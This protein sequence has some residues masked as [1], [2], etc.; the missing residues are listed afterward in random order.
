[1][2]RSGYSQWTSK[3][4]ARLLTL[5]ESE[6]RHYQ[7]ILAA[8]PIPLAVLAADRSII[9][10]NRAFRKMFSVGRD[11][12]AGKTLD[13]L[14]PSPVALERLV[15]RL[16]DLHTRSA[17]E[18]SDLVVGLE[19]KK[20]RLLL[21]P[22]RDDE[23]EAG[24]QTLLAVLDVSGPAVSPA[25]AEAA[26]SPPAPQPLTGE[27][28]P[29]VIWQADVSLKFTSVTGAPDRLLG[30][31]A[32]HWTRKADFFSAR[33]H[34]EDREGVIALY[35]STM[36][37]GGDCS[38]EFRV[39]TR[40]GESVWCR[41]TIHAA[42][43]AITG[44]LT[45]IDQRRQ[46]EHL[47]LIAERHAALQAL[48]ARLAHDLNNP[49]MIITGYAEE[50]LGAIPADDPHRA[51][52]EQ[53][54]AATDRIAGITGQ[55]LQFTRKHALPAQR[56]EISE[57]LRTLERQIRMAAGSGTR[58]DLSTVTPTFALAEPTQLQE[59]LLSVI[60]RVSV[61]MRGSALVPPSRE[62]AASRNRLRITCG[63]TRITE[64]LS[65]PER[66]APVLDP[67]TYAHITLQGAGP[68]LGAET[69]AFETLLA[70]GKEG[71]GAT[72]PARAYQIVREWGGD[73]LYASEPTSRDEKTPGWSLV[74]YLPQAEPGEA[75]QLASPPATQTPEE[76]ARPTILVVDDEP[77]IRSLI[78]KILRR[79]KYDVVEAGS[80]SEALAT[81]TAHKGSLDLLL[82]DVMLPDGSGLELAERLRE[83]L[84]AVKILY[85]S[86]YTS[87]EAVR[88][89]AQPPGAKFLQKPFTLNALLEKVRE[90]AG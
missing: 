63:T 16:R 34:P 25:V 81:A 72:T 24:R 55:L 9:S 53:I 85:I 41:E 32:A 57:W 37:S 64:R 48:A 68:G 11:E 47:H 22:L 79:E 56:L 80:V 40:T 70:A 67:A 43:E 4:V 15:E 71:E 18:A 26:A 50:M 36:R 82:T 1:M 61:A 19:G 74:I 14:I 21:A 87:D 33:I 12:I 90:A 31:P 13:S 20:L 17:D 3:E 59:I 65:V 78:A 76:H 51:D 27:Y 73:L 28:L 8:L 86:G 30:Y 69:A 60:T 35:R 66:R 62:E 84:P 49:L 83:R 10:T 58:V 88:Q 23:D 5:V 75:P 77:D 46:L 54:L 44:V 89:G 52:A 45:R 2:E 6:R 39:I 7:D 29:A 38:A 42:G